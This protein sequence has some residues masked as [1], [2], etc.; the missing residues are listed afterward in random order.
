MNLYDIKR[1]R[2]GREMAEGAKVTANNDHEAIEKAQRLFSG[3]EFADDR[4]AIKGVYELPSSHGLTEAD[5]RLADEYD[6]ANWP[7][8]R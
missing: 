5:C 7:A 8:P 3:P 2:G 6:R 4:F 1:Y